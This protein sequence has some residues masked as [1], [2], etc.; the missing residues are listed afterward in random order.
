MASKEARKEAIRKASANSTGGSIWIRRAADAKIVSKERKNSV[1]EYEA[2]IARL[3]SQ[4]DVAEAEKDEWWAI[5][6][7]YEKAL[8]RIEKKHVLEPQ[9][10][11]IARAALEGEDDE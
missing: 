8:R 9:A 11:R 3:A 5:A 6:E 1:S 4:L 2:R 7:R 10:A